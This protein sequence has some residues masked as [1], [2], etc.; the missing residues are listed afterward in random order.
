[1]ITVEVDKSDM[2][3]VQ[4]ALGKISK[5][6]PKVI[7]RAI[8]KT[9]TKSKTSLAEK[10]RSVYTVKSGK[11]K[12]NMNIKRA[13]YSRLEAEVKAHGKPLSITAFKTTAPKSGAKAN[14]VKGNGLKVLNLGGIKAFKGKGKL[15]G[16]I[17]QRRGKSRFPIKKLSSNSV[18]IM[19]GNEK[20]YGQIEPDIKSELQKNIDAQ[21]KYLLSTAG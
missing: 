17:Y 14:I 6:A 2:R 13:T 11:F 16:Q 3:R 5:D 20:V 19:I 8:N 21:I 1:M 7:C 18:P 10:A 12:N 15:N 9:A 4:E